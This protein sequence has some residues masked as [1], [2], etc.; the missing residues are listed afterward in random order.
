MARAQSSRRKSRGATSG[1]RFM[2]LREIVGPTTY[3]VW[4]EMLAQLVPESRTHRIAPLV[5]GMLQFASKKSF[6]LSRGR[7]AKGSLAEA[8]AYGPDDPDEFDS[9]LN[10]GTVPEGSEQVT[11]RGAVARLFRDAKVK[12]VRTNAKGDRYSIVDAILMEYHQWHL[13]PWE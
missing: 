11:I 6:P 1:R 7:L 3:S 9:S 4:T 8:L 10:T 5:A 13:M 12:Y 2:T